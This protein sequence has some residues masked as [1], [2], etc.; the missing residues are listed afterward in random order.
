MRQPTARTE[1]R[2]RVDSRDGYVFWDVYLDGRYR[3]TL[4]TRREARTVAADLRAAA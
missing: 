2:R 1:V 4:C 3:T